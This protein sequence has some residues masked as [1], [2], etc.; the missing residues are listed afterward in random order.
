MAE[1]VVDHLDGYAPQDVKEPPHAANPALD[2]SVLELLA[3]VDQARLDAFINEMTGVGD[4]NRDKTMGGQ[5]DGVLRVNLRFL[6]GAACRDRWR[7]TDLGSRI[8]EQIPSEMTREGYEL[9]VQPTEDDAFNLDGR[10]AARAD[11]IAAERAR[12]G[13]GGKEW[14]ALC[15][16]RRYMTDEQWR[17]VLARRRA[18]RDAAPPVPAGRQAAR[19]SSGAIEAEDDDKGQAIVEALEAKLRDLGALDKVREA[20][21]YERAYGG[22]VVLIGAADASA[23]KPYQ[24]GHGLRLDASDKRNLTAPLDEKRI[25]SIKHLTPLRGG[26]DGEVIA[27]SYY[28]DITSPRYGEPEIYM[29]RNIGVPIARPPA[30]GESPEQIQ[31]SYDLPHLTATGGPLTYWVHE[32][33]LLVF[34]GTAADHFARVQMRGWG[35]PIF[36]KVDEVLSQ[37]GQTWNS[38][39]IIMQEFAQGI[40]KIDGF[41]K[42]MATNDPKGMGALRTRAL[43]LFMTQSIARS[44]IIDKNEEFSRVTV[45]LTGLAEVLE[46]FTLRMAAAA[47]MPVSL[48]FG[49]SPG[50]LRAGDDDRMFFYDRVKSKQ[51]SNVVPQWRRLLRLL[52]IAKDGP[53]GGVEP[54]RWAVEPRPLWQPTEKEV[55]ELRKLVAETDE[56]NIRAQIYT[57]EEA[58]ASHYGGAKFSMDVTLDL[59]ARHA[60]ANLPPEEDGEFGAPGAPAGAGNPTDAPPP[61]EKA[62]ELGLTATSLSAIVT[63]NEARAARGLPPWPGADGNLTVAEFEAK[64]AAVIA[65]AANAEAGSVGAPPQADQS[66]PAPNFAQ[67]APKPGDGDNKPQANQGEGGEP[68]SP[69][70]PGDGERDVKPGK[71]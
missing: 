18:R 5:P 25:G 35:D 40:L 17:D 29:L 36:M 23:R 7:G 22:G 52:L 44:R 47:D 54:K 58:A 49:Q 62:P 13:F 37:F 65:I 31:A 56:I 50:G 21:N 26:W 24:D 14:A 70:S 57:P 27:W 66:P 2:P 64:R 9:T 12:W 53:T 46:Q 51:L 48:L 32:S 16:V 39:A 71:P 1:R 67:N 8:V 68:L 10:T 63:V 61:D 19:P 15:R 41:A 34:P 38:I 4:F 60:M 30:P 55:A 28:N 59:E 3:N 43:A 6:S 11:G 45:P 20:L 69:D 33:R 42:L